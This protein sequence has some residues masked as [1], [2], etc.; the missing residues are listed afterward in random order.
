MSTF[1]IL[2]PRECLELAVTDF[3]DRLI[4]GLPAPDGL[5]ERILDALSDQ[6]DLFIVHREDLTG[7]GELAEELA[8]GFGAEPRDRVVEVGMPVGSAPAPI[9][10]WTVPATVPDRRVA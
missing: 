1:F 2:P 4:P 9:R 10:V 8:E 3:L 7:S 5:C 6:R